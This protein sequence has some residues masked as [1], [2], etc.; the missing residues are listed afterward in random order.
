MRCLPGTGTASGRS[1][2]MAPGPSGVFRCP[3]SVFCGTCASMRWAD[4]PLG[5]AR[6]NP[7]RI[8]LCGLPWDWSPIPISCFLV[9]SCAARYCLRGRGG[10][11]PAATCPETTIPSYLHGE[12]RRAAKM[13]SLSLL[14]FVLHKYGACHFWGLLPLVLAAES[15]WV[16][17]QLRA[18]LKTSLHHHR[19]AIQVVLRK[20]GAWHFLSSKSLV[21][22]APS[23]PI[24]LNLSLVAFSS[25]S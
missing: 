16:P 22:P 5:T 11:G 18:V 7:S 10:L 8:S 2:R 4:V 17:L 23:E 1:A 20:S 19:I 6:N 25:P 3:E 15:D 14:L 9:A 13:R 12:P 21:L 24:L